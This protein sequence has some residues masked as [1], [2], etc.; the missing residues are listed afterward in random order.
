[1]KRNVPPWV[2]LALVC[3]AQFMVVLDV[4][5]VNV[6]LPAIAADLKVEAEGLQ[7]IVNA[8][9]LT[10]AGFLLLGGRAADL[11]GR[12]LVFILGLVLFSVSSLVGGFADTPGVLIAARA[13][14]GLGAA[15]LSPATLTILTTT[16]ADGPMRARAIATWGAVGAAG[17]AAGS[18]VGG[19]LTD[20][21]SWRW[22]L[23]INVPIGAV[24]VAVA[25]LALAESRDATRA[26]RLDVTGAVLVTLGLTALEYG[27]VGTHDHGWGSARALVPM[28]VGAL[29]LAAF[30]LW[31]AR[32]A[33]APLMPLR[34]FRSRSVTGAN[35]VQFLLGVAGFAVWYFLSLYMQN[36]LGYTA[37]Q[38]GLA[39]IPHTTMII[40]ASKSTPRLVARFGF[41]PLLV[42][43]ALI[44]A[45]GFLW[46]A[47][48]TPGSG[49]VTGVLLPGMLITGGMGLTFAPI[50]MAATSGVSHDE[51]GLVSGVLNSSRQVGGSLGLAAL[52][53]VSTTHTASLAAGT[54]APAA[55]TAGYALAFLVCAGVLLAAAAA[56]FAL[57]RARA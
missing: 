41:R 8:Y 53:T 47:Q 23:L 55:L 36:V 49:L 18:V 24:A 16:F 35:L 3:M 52:A 22:I 34:I 1:M 46:Q 37:I 7:W 6:A 44:S 19:V 2:V 25:L 39:F 13:V 43:G 4:S 26:R 56:V 51:A 9:V 21:V 50:A 38:A 20:L 27:L 15:V 57:P 12:K 11:F 33:A 30:V 10:S 28:I 48:I 31:Q 40:I 42:V 29:A 5:V 32:F 17:G 54:P 45:S 14:Q